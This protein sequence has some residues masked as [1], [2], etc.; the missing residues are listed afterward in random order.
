MSS[1]YCAKSI[2]ESSELLLRNGHSINDRV[3]VL[4]GYAHYPVIETTVECSINAID[5]LTAIGTDQWLLHST[6][7]YVIEIFYNGEITIG[8]RN[9]H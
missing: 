4:W 9:S 5:D 3:Y 6:T 2:I 1:H 8:F 7:R